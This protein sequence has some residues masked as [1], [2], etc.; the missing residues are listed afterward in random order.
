MTQPELGQK[1]SALRQAQGLTQTE[2]FEKCNLSLRTVQR[3]EGAEVTPRV[4]TIKQVFEALGED[5]FFESRLESVGKKGRFSDFIK[6]SMLTSKKMRIL[7][8]I[9][10]LL[11]S[12][13]L[14]FLGISDYQKTK[15]YQQNGAGTEKI[16]FDM[17]SAFNSGDMKQI[18]EVYLNT[19]TLMPVNAK[20]IQGREDIISYYQSVYDSGFRLISDKTTSLQVTDS[21]AIETG[22]W[23]GFN[24]QSF[25]GSYFAQWKKVDGKWYIENYMTNYDKDY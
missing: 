24:G 23:T 21:I 22:T 25:D 14:L 7:I 10:I 17:I 4:Y 19:A 1:I 12:A 3:I 16:D 15:I 11:G 9:S 13:G 2:L 20:T 8:A 5:Y 18:G 6:S